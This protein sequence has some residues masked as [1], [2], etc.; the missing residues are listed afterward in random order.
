MSSVLPQDGCLCKENY[1]IDKSGV[2]LEADF[3][4]FCSLAIPTLLSKYLDNLEIEKESIFC[5][6]NVVYN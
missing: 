6:K 3:I 1:N 5:Q 2:I 4:T